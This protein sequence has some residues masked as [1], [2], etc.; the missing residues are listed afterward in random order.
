[1]WRDIAVENV[2]V[3]TQT[4]RRKG[5]ILMRN[6]PP[7]KI[8]RLNAHAESTDHTD[9]CVDQLYSSYVAAQGGVTDTQASYNFT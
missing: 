5:R 9:S 4:G 8:F 3:S 7:E 6:I 2:G 1:M